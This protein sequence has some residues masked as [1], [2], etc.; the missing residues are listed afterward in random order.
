MCLSYSHLSF[1]VR[2]RIA[3][4]TEKSITLLHKLFRTV[5]T[6]HP[7]QSAVDYWQT[8]NSILITSNNTAHE[9]WRDEKI[10]HLESIAA[11]KTE[12]LD[13]LASERTKIMG[14][15]REDAIKQLIRTSKI[16]NKMSVIKGIRDN[17]LFE[18]SSDVTSLSSSHHQEG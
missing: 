7:S 4:G 14:L 17:G 16:D 18:I 12:A 6:I 1:L 5:E 15:S 8:I 3:E 11:A 2:F 13:Y 9:L 10:A